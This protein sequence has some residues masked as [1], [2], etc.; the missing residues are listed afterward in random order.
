M[1]VKIA[2]FCANFKV[3]KKVLPLLLL[4]LMAF[5]SC[6]RS[7]AMYQMAEKPNEVAVN[8][9]QFVKQT[10]KRAKHYTAEDWQL[11]IE[12]FTAMSKNCFEN[13]SEMS[14]EDLSRFDRARVDFM[15]VVTDSGSEEL[16]LQ[17]KEIYSNI[18][19]R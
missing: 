15:K 18:Y 4:V 7:P 17:I 6:H 13:Q 2:Y 8:A 11:A 1:I 12:Q 19:N 10:A 3:M 5:S 16:A 9:E 14:Q